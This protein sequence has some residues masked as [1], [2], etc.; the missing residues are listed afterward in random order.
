MNYKNK[1]FKKIFSIALTIILLST[2]LTTFFTSTS[3]ADQRNNNPVG[4]DKGPSYTSVVPLKK[5]TFINYDENSYLDDYAFLASIPTAVFKDKETLYSNPLLFYTDQTN[6]KGREKTLNYRQGIDYLMEDWMGYSNG[7]LDQLVTV[8]VD[9]KD[10][11]QWN[12]REY[13]IIEGQDPYTLAKKIALNDWSF[14][15]DIVV[16]VI[17]DQ[18]NKNNDAVTNKITGTLPSRNVKEER[19]F[20]L[21]QTNSLN[22]V[23]QSFTVE[24]DYVFLTA[25]VWWE[26]ILIAD[27]MIPTGDPDLQIYCK[28]DGEWI[29]TVASASWNIYK[30]AGHEV[31]SAYIYNPG[32]WRIAVTDYPTEGQPPRTGL[33]NLFEIQGNPLRSFL[34]SPVKSLIEKFRGDVTYNVDITKYPGTHID[35]PDLP[36]FGTR[37][38]YF[39]LSW[40]RDDVNLGFTLIGPSGEAVYT[41]NEDNEKNMQTMYLKQLGEVLEGGKGYKIA[42]FSTD[43]INRPIDFNIEYSWKQEMTLEKSDSLTSATEGAILASQLNAP[44][45]YTSK[46][47][48]PQITKD[49]LYKLGVRNIYLVDINSNLNNDVKDELSRIAKIKE[50][51]DYRSIYDK[52]KTLSGNPQD[53][54]FSTLEPWTKWY[55]DELRP[56]DQTRAGLVIGP[57]AYIAAHHGTPV[58]FVENHPRLSQALTYHNTFWR[59]HSNERYEYKPSMAEMILTGTQIYDF[60]GDYGFD[61]EGPETIITV[62]DQYDIGISWDRIFPGVANSG[63]ICGSPVDTATWISRSTFYPCL[64]FQNPAT[65]GSVELINGSKSSYD[66]GLKVG[67]DPIFDINLGRFKIERESGYEEFNFPVLCSHVKHQH[68]FN[69]RGSQYYGDKYQTADGLIPGN[70]YTMNPIDQ[71]VM[72]KLTG[73]E[74][75]LFPDMTETHV[76]PFY[77]N[78]GGYD[79]AFSTKLEAVVEN[80]NKGVLLWVHTSHGSEPNGGQTLFW[81]PAAGF[82]YNPHLLPSLISGLYNIYSLLYSIPLIGPT[83]YTWFF[84][85]FVLPGA[86]LEENPWRGYDWQMGSTYEPDT[87]SMDIKGFLPYTNLN[88]PFMPAMGLTWV[89]ARKPIREFINSILPIDL[90]EVD[91]LYDGV[92]GAI[93]QSKAPLVNKNATQI[94]E[95]LGNLHSSGFITSICQTSN[96]YL[97]LMMIRH[98]SVFQV[99]DPWPTSWYGAVW[100]QSIPRDIILGDTVGEAFTKGMSHV[101]PLYLSEQWWWDDAE[102]VVYFG[103]PDLRMF[104]PSTDYS[105]KNYWIQEDVKPIRYDKELNINGHMPF[106][107]TEYPH[108]RKPETWFARY[109]PVIIILVLIIIILIAMMAMGKRKN[110]RGE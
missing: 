87:M 47:E 86:L 69:E 92:T 109:M 57:A 30:P 103:D 35:I 4:F 79:V 7:L 41:V 84:G 91:N 38:A 43:D 36:S 45:L 76:I 37:N 2:L 101:G 55:F 44:L 82:E 39:N 32:E 83:L 14:S 99:Q 42:V 6:Y 85:T 29:Q 54:V 105:D 40:D 25:V 24:E 77:L 17:S 22:P 70:T 28:Y 107:A 94:E 97:H 72:A 11:E 8:N 73:D 58:V 46:D 18:F 1:Q 3:L 62:A 65:Q 16:S 108:E 13:K 64:I 15:D 102:N 26:G 56:G 75:M 98:G 63:R 50:Y 66:V 49:A 51:T 48:L 95:N 60:L 61:L 34:S 104:V 20:T 100:R 10:V 81:D 19:L 106:G 9:K 90:F 27:K 59:K 88:I 52:I 31:A 21:K 89:L 68:R 23:S 5:T 12:A 80:L 110:K 71:G 96:T 78:R 74:G 93:G 67:R 53:I 33:E